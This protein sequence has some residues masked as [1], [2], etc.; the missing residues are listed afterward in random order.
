MSFYALRTPPIMPQ[1]LQ[2]ASIVR[3]YNPAGA[4]PLPSIEVNRR[5]PADRF[6]L[7]LLNRVSPQL[8]PE[9]IFSLLISRQLISLLPSPTSLSL[10]PPANLYQ[11][12]LNSRGCAVEEG[13]NVHRSG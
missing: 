5:Y 2:P 8:R 10:F 12:Y 6:N 3:M 7:P 13:R 1:L 4:H 11:E 9:V